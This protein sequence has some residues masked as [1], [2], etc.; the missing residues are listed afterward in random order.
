MDKIYLSAIRGMPRPLAFPCY[1]GGYCSNGVIVAVDKFKNRIYACLQVASYRV[2]C[3]V[4]GKSNYFL[5][6]S[7]WKSGGSWGV[8]FLVLWP[9]VWRLGD[10]IRPRLAWRL[11]HEILA[12]GGKAVGPV[13]Y[14]ENNDPQRLVGL[15]STIIDRASRPHGRGY[16]AEREALT[17][18]LHRAYMEYTGLASHV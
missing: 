6:I 3:G 7:K 17:R 11:R 10:A 12:S 5:L 13:F 15:A 8:P 16:K 14:I 2:L 1:I 18:A 9:R 4:G